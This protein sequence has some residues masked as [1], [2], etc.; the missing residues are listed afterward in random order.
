MMISEK[1]VIEHDRVIGYVG[2]NDSNQLFARIEGHGW[3]AIPL[4]DLRGVSNAKAVEAL[5]YAI[6]A[7]H[8]ASSGYL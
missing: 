2:T 4:S 7:N 8:Y 6:S 3:E 5:R 1:A